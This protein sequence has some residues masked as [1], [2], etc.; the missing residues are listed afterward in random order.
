M[1]Y[2]Y[3]FYCSGSA[4]RV[5]KFYEV[6]KIDECPAE[7]IFYDGFRNDIC[8]SLK[9]ITENIIT[10]DSGLFN[11]KKGRLLSEYLSSEILRSLIDNNVDYL[12]CFG[13]KI[14]KEELIRVYNYK[15][16]NFHPSILP[17]FPG[18]YA[19]DQALKSSIQLLENTAHFIDNGIDSGL[20]ILQS[21]ISKSSFEN[22]DSVLNLQIPMLKKNMELVRK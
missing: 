19:I 3:A 15:I 11:S 2:K 1:K 8:A 16:I 20:I 9:N 7:F 5:L 4:S 6:N 10:P 21:V 17:S 12:F 22:Y 13:D 18:L 14:L